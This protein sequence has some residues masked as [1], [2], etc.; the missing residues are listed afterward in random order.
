MGKNKEHLKFMISDGSQN[1]ETIGWRMAPMFI[2]LKNKNITIDLAFQPEINEWRNTRRAQLILNDI[3]I[4][5]PRSKIQDIYPPLNV[6]S[7]VKIF[8]RRSCNKLD[9]LRK[10]LARE[11][12]TFLYV[13][14][15]AA[16]QQLAKMGEGARV[17]LSSDECRVPIINNL[18]LCSTEL[19]ND[20]R[21]ELLQQFERGQLSTIASNVIFEHLPYVKHFVFCHPVPTWNIFSDCCKPA[22]E[23]E[24]TTYVHLIFGAK[25]IGVMQDMLEWEYPSREVL[26][27]LYKLIENIAQKNGSLVELDELMKQS[28]PLSIEEQTV[29]SAITIF[30]E[31]QLVEIPS[32]LDFTN[33]H[34]LSKPQQKR[35]LNESEFFLKGEQL[36]QV[37]LSFSDFFLKKTPEDLF[38]E[39][40][41]G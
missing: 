32:A 25:D 30:E 22:F 9:Y 12:R 39:L 8:D 13:R 40:K 36:K 3:H 26:G 37:A 33:I 31:L 16:L 27:K 6:P 11:E 15:D 19:D 17:P 29:R 35:S 4:N 21:Q 41:R 38:R 14:N 7:S 1:L 23:T 18:G 28:T 2:A 24:E 34:F 5:S 10:L 20:Q